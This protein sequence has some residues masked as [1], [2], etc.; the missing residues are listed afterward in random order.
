MKRIL[1][2]LLALCSASF[3][4]EFSPRKANPTEVRI[5]PVRPTPEP[6]NVELSITFPKMDQVV[7][8]YSL[9]VQLQLEGFNVGTN[10]DF[11]RAKQIYNDP[12]GQSVL[13]FIDD[14]EPF[15]I[16][17]SFVDALDNNNLYYNWTLNQV[18]PFS[19]K[20]GFHVIRAF[21]ARSFGEGLKGPGRF[22]VRR[23]YVG[24]RK[25]YLDVDLCAPY[26]T[27]NEPLESLTYC[28]HQPILLDFYL[29]NIQLS[30]DGYKVRVT[31]DG[32]ITRILTQWVPYYIYGIPSGR[33]TIEL[34]LIN[35]KNEV[36][37]GAFN[38][39]KRT[40]TVS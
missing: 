34:E 11:D 24:E 37:P 17:K 29:T 12:M 13:V 39:V 36:A 28:P 10:S 20:E 2:L 5:V 23:F 32:D 1:F 38:K 22:A 16:Y 4:A 26:L 30:Q 14:H 40:I 35:E 27:Y 18:I 3:A 33:H 21:P 25:A 31:I 15:E 9:D 6:D 8:G 7:S 19:L